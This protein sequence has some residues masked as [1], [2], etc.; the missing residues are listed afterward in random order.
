MSFD[1][2]LVMLAGTGLIGFIWWFFFG[3]REPVKIDGFVDILVS[4]GYTPSVIEIK[5]NSVTTLKIT[6]KDSNPC[7]EE[8]VLSDFKVKKYLPINEEVKITIKI[9]KRG[10]YMFQCGMNMFHGKIIVE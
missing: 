5:R 10:V 3:K 8:F 4:G 2:I 6:R 7:L 9:P 1:K